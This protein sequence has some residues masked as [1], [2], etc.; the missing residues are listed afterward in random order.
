M[1]LHCQPQGLSPR[2]PQHHASQGQHSS[3]L[4][5]NSE[6]PIDPCPKSPF[7][8][9]WELF[10]FTTEILLGCP[11]PLL[12]LPDTY[13]SWIFKYCLLLFLPYSWSPSEWGS[14]RPWL[15]PR[16]NCFK[17]YWFLLL[18]HAGIH[19]PTITSLLLSIITHPT[20]I[21]TTLIHPFACKRQQTPQVYSNPHKTLWTGEWP[22]LNLPWHEGV[23]G[24]SS[25]QHCK[26]SRLLAP[27]PLSSIQDFFH[28]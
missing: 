8:L 6:L 11:L 28:L 23:Q 5:P 16:N 17:N 1:F 2:L 22:Q 9:L 12:S 18:L 10:F 24:L 26:G 13:Y 4:N 7:E 15:T 21:V 27:S 19:L 14:P 3:P 20:L 25:Q